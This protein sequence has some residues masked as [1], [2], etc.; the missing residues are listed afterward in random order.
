VFAI[1]G[2]A[3]SALSWLINPWFL[4]SLVGLGFSVRA[5]VRVR[6]ITGRPHRIIFVLGVIG[7]VVGVVGLI[8]SI[9]SIAIRTG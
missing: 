1:C 7:V 6:R 4:I 9:L 8:G 3:L 2:L 5:L